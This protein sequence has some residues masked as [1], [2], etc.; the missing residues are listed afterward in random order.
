MT[1]RAPLT[2]L[3]DLLSLVFLAGLALLPPTPRR[4]GSTSC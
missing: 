3:D 4:M 2:E 1:P